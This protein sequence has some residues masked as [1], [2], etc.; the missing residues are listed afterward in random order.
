[1]RDQI[2]WRY[3]RDGG[4]QHA[5]TFSGLKLAPASLCGERWAW[6][7]P[8]GEARW[9]GAADDSEREHL[10]SLPQCGRCSRIMSLSV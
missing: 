4:R 5:V 10:A 7:M 8:A 9:M 6:W 2:V 3:L 1:M